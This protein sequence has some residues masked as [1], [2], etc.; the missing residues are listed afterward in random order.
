MPSQGIKWDQ[1]KGEVQ[2]LLLKKPTQA[3]AQ[4]GLLLSFLL[5]FSL[6][7]FFFAIKT[8]SPFSNAS[9]RTWRGR[10]SRKTT[11][12]LGK[13]SGRERSRGGSAGRRQRGRG[14]EKLPWGLR[15]LPP[16]ERVLASRGTSTPPSSSSSRR[17]TW[18]DRRSTSRRR[19][20]SCACRTQ[21]APV[22][23]GME[24]RRGDVDKVTCALEVLRGRRSRMRWEL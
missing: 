20:P 18:T 24:W 10:G 1:N 22:G 9:S 21:P 8:L 23:E 13:R 14:K 11:A 4:K 16:W 3:R 15:L 17:W 7:F 5:S 6:S 12:L 2:L 19:S